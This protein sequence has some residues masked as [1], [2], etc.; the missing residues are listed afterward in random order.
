MAMR[1][2]GQLLPVLAMP[3]VPITVAM[4]TTT[5][6]STLLTSPADSV[7]VWSSVDCFIRFGGVSVDATTASHPLTAKVP[8]IFQLD[9]NQY[10]AGIVSTGT[11]TLFV[12][13][14]T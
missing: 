13:P 2:Q 11:G 4:S 12:S 10:V 7:R 14:L 8:E 9:S 6:R 3:G 1:V 5:A